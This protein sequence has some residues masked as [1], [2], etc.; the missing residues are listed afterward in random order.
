MSKNRILKKLTA[1]IF[2]ESCHKC[3]ALQMISTTTVRWRP[4]QPSSSFSSLLGLYVL[5]QVSWAIAPRLS[6]AWKRT[7]RKAFL[8]TSFVLT[9]HVKLLEKRS[10]TTLKLREAGFRKPFSEKVFVL[11]GFVFLI[12]VIRS[13]WKL[14][15]RYS[16]SDTTIWTALAPVFTLSCCLVKNERQC[17]F[18]KSV[19]V[20]IL[21]I[22]ATFV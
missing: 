3:F 17:S 11:T 2:S 10:Q 13:W 1:A 7:K 16:T 6:W 5:S 9:Q 22:K 14:D 12:W 21:C 8:S 15:D 4:L 18:Y 20:Q 19:Y